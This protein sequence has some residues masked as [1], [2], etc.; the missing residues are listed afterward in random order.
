MT[1]SF[2]GSLFFLRSRARREERTCEQGWFHHYK[3]L[4]KITTK[5]SHLSEEQCQL[6]YSRQRT[7]QAHLSAATHPLLVQIPWLYSRQREVRHGHGTDCWGHACRR[8]SRWQCNDLTRRQISMLVLHS[9]AYLCIFQFLSHEGFLSDQ[10]V[11]SISHPL[12]LP[13]SSPNFVPPRSLTPSLLYYFFFPLKNF[14]H[15]E[16]KE[17]GSQVGASLCHV[18]PKITTSK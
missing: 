6:R 10:Y 12:I 13:K 3:T 4:S 16:W 7:V 18:Q 8:T 5:C 2:L 11:K 1:T 17:F 9:L 15:F 14:G